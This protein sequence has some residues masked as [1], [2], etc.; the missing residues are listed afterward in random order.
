MTAK[1]LVLLATVAL[2]AASFGQAW[3]RSYD[4]G[5]AAARG[6]KWALA[7]EEF[8]RAA[9]NRPDDRSGPTI[10]PGPATERRVW[11]EG[12][13]Y[14]PNFLAAYS[15]YRQSLNTIDPKESGDMLRTAAGEL[16][17]LLDKGQDSVEAYFYLDLI[18]TRLDDPAKRKA[19][20]DRL[21]KLGHRPDFKVDTEPVAPE[22]AASMQAQTQNG[23]PVLPGTPTQPGIYGPGD[24][25]KNTLPPVVANVPPLKEK[26]A[27]VVGQS[28]S[29]LSGGM[30]P[31]GATDAERIRS[32][33]INF[34]GYPSENVTLLKD[35]SAADMRAAAKAIAAKLPESATVLVY[36]A[37]AATN[38]D[39][40]DY[41]AG[42]DTE[43]GGDVGSMYAKSEL[44]TTFG[45]RGARVF[46]FFEVNRPMDANGS[47]FGRE[48]VAGGSVAQ[49]QAT[50]PGESVTS[51]YRDNQQLG[52]FG[53]AFALTLA[54]YR[55]NQIPIQE[56]FWQVFNAM[57]RGDTGTTGGS[58]RQV[59]T[60]P[61]LIGLAADSKF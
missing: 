14:S 61:I 51:T 46:A 4:A 60:L 1:P 30:V 16:E 26:F 32:A 3:I 48:T 45:Q 20:A 58:T 54:N 55:T 49:V 22:E 10:M 37:G 9:A 18:Y 34:A 29:H 19:L 31:F 2:S 39:G 15:L 42:A 41:F 35:A 17:M 7:R 52:L 44:Y 53:N 40:K 12:K 43:S 23:G 11:R 28:A 56:F 59:P 50:R 57:K 38:L 36:Y 27:L 13:P 47:Y 24:I 8:G 33:L 6:K 25:G 21:A 5:L